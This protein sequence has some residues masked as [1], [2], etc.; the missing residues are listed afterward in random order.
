MQVASDA[1][2]R[3]SASEIA[4]LTAQVKGLQDALQAATQAR[5]SAKSQ[6]KTLATASAAINSEENSSAA[7][8]RRAAAAKSVIQTLT[9]QVTDSFQ[10]TGQLKRSEAEFAMSVAQVTNLRS[11]SSSP[12]KSLK[13]ERSTQDLLLFKKVCSAALHK[14]LRI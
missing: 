12:Q 9:S 11:R 6:S 8:L 10:G 7:V 14:L 1:E 2:T 3:Q 13:L 5:K 4:Q